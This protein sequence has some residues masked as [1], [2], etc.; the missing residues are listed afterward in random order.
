MCTDKQGRILIPTRLRV[1]SGIEKDIVF[2]GMSNRIE[3]W[4][5]ISGMLIMNEE[6]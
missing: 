3:V 2:I 1:Y 4:S 5:N 6:L